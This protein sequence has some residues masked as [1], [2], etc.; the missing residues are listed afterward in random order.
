[1]PR[2]QVPETQIPEENEKLFI[3]QT[4]AYCRAQDVGT[5]DG[6]FDLAQD[7]LGYREWLVRLVQGRAIVSVPKRN[8][9]KVQA[10]GSE[11]ATDRVNWQGVICTLVYNERRN[12]QWN[13]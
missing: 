10:N 1:M 2:L 13:E 4:K 5:C 11:R 8:G 3:E 12:E 7:A 9:S 6:L